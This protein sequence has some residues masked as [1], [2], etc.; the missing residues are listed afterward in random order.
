MILSA[1]IIGRTDSGIDTHGFEHT[2]FLPIE[3]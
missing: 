1:E 3:A 2:S